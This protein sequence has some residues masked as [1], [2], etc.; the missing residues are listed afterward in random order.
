MLFQV[1]FGKRLV[2]LYLDL[3]VDGRGAD[4]LAIGKLTNGFDSEGKYMAGL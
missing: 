2:M 4:K 1:T 3:E